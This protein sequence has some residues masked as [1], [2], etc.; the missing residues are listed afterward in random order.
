MCNVFS[1]ILMGTS[2]S[3]TSPLAPAFERMSTWDLKASRGLLQTYK[4]K[5]MDFGLDSQGLTEL[6]GG[7]KDW[8]ENII[9]AFRGSSGI[10]NALAFICGACL[11]SSGP[12]LEKAGSNVELY[13]HVVLLIFDGLDF[14]GTEQISMDEMTIAF[15]CC[16][17]GFCVISGVGT[18]PSDEELESVTLQ[19]YRELNKGSTQSITKSEFTKWILEFASGTGTPFTREVTLENVLKQFRL[20]PST[21]KDEENE[22]NNL[23]SPPLE[24]FKAQDQVD[25]LQSHVAEDS[26]SFESEV[27]VDEQDADMIS[28]NGKEEETVENEAHG[29]EE[30]LAED[31]YVET[32]EL[33]GTSA[34]AESD[35]PRF[36]ADTEEDQNNFVHRQAEDYLAHKTN[37]K[38]TTSLTVQQDVA[39]EDDDTQYEQDDDF[40]QETPRLNADAD[41]DANIS[42]PGDPSEGDHPSETQTASVELS[43]QMSEAVANIDETE[44]QSIEAED[45]TEEVVNNEVD[46]NEPSAMAPDADIDAGK[47]QFLDLGLR[48]T[49]SGTDPTVEPPRTD[50]NALNDYQDPRFDG[51]SGLP[52]PEPLELQDNSA[53]VLN[54]SIEAD[55]PAKANIDS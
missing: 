8:A 55:T 54:D 45:G 21:E 17:R 24:T 27:V 39:G 48:S 28:N 16:A 7:D 20:V 3:K 36:V 10:I 26:K 6:L 13:F 4:D 49:I 1:P 22:D 12:A 5:D 33:C 11:V 29:L 40:A 47:K 46:T 23:F 9:D 37:D 19:A 53:Q 50:P 43:A 41:A 38:D 44:V 34:D 52:P 30:Q 32:A 25:E 14:D 35:Y 42:L 15:L 51:S 18:V 2:P 31:S